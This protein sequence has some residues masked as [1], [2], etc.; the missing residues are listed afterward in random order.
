MVL[1][2][3]QKPLLV[4]NVEQ[5]WV[6]VQAIQTF[7]KSRWP[8]HRRDQSGHVVRHEK[9]VQPGASFVR[10]MPVWVEVA[11]SEVHDARAEDRILEAKGA[12]HEP[13][14]EKASKASVSA[15]DR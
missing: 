4:T 3:W 11:R 5:V 2:D 6:L 13:G 12:I 15:I 10:L 7:D 8:S 14:H 1:K 9:G